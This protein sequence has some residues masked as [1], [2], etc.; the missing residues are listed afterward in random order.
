VFLNLFLEHTEYGSITDSFNMYA[1]TTADACLYVLGADEIGTVLAALC[2]D[3]RT[4][5]YRYGGPGILYALDLR[6]AKAAQ[7]G[8][9]ELR[10]GKFQLATWL[11]RSPGGKVIQPWA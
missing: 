6:K 10:D 5:P 11:T 1:P 3:L 2:S 9:I 7:D 4:E 8:L